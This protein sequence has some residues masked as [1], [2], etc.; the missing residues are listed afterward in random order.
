M[1]FSRLTSI[2][3]ALALTVLSAPAFA[4]GAGTG[5]NNGR[6]WFVAGSTLTADGN[7]LVLVPVEALSNPSF[8]LD[9]LSSR[10]A[11]SA[12]VLLAKVDDQSR[13]FYQAA[14]LT[15]VRAGGAVVDWLRGSKASFWASA[16][17]NCR[18]AALLLKD[19]CTTA[20]P[21][22]YS[23]GLNWLGSSELKVAVQ[24][25][26]LDS[27]MSGTYLAL[28]ASWFADG[29]RAPLPFSAKGVGYQTAAS[30]LFGTT[31]VGLNAERTV[32]PNLSASS[33][34]Q[35]DE[36]RL[37]VQKGKIGG[38]LA[39]R[40]V[41]IDRTTQQLKPLAGVDLGVFMNLPW[42]ANLKVGAS[43]TSSKSTISSIQRDGQIVDRVAYIRY[44]QD[45]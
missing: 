45:L 42:R 33:G 18:G 26:S 40:V 27:S 25:A 19:Q 13:P 10:G 30:L 9:A 8:S 2:C 3:A 31:R 39:G 23:A 37:F 20:S 22:G 24:P 21:Q 4:E 17:N 36:L 35:Q 1:I 6:Q 14:L 15:S 28:P 16:A 7:D 38:S 41:R 11:K 32:F 43:E 29:Y 34:L 12:P 44:Q 5:Q